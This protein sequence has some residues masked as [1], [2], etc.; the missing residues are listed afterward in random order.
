MSDQRGQTIS[1][2]A[3]WLDLMTAD[4]VAAVLH[5]TRKAVYAM[6]ERALLPPP[7]RLGRRLLFRKYDL[8]TYLKE[9][10]AASPGGDGR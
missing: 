3:E 1:K 5:T 10:R 9:R 4:D 6:T 7:I 2:D 8:V